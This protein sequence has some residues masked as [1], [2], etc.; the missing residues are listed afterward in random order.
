MTSTEKDNNEG[1]QQIQFKGGEKSTTISN[2]SLQANV[3]EDT[4]ER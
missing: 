4:E 3:D 2:P 1:L